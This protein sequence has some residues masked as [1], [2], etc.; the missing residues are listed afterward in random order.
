MTTVARDY[1]NALARFEDK[2]KVRRYSQS[3]CRSYYFMFR[4]FLKAKYP[5][6][7]HHLNKDDIMEYQLQLVSQRNVSR[8]YQNQSI[9]AIKF[10]LEHV[11][12]HDR[13]LFN[14]ERPL[15]EKKL[16]QVL[17]QQEVK[18]ILEQVYN[19][20]H[21]AILTTIYASGLRISELINLEI[22]DIDSA[23]MRI[24][25]WGGKGAKDRF[26]VLSPH[27]LKLLRQYFVKHKP[28]GYLF[29]GANN[30]QPYSTTSIR[31]VLARAVKKAG[32]IKPVTVHTLRHS[33]ATHLLENGTNL[34]YIQ[35]LLGHGSSK[36]TEIYTHVCSTK[37]TDVAS[38]L[39]KLMEKGLI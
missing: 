39:D 10:Y 18:N 22:K 35:E 27:L 5:K 24:W 13:Q 12:G 7:L 1:Q 14:L 37:L 2:L 25:V 32:I 11:L 9:N 6:P 21:K 33:F 28:S 36:T 19:L 30:G 17:N 29:E 26:T 31:K 34:R 8:S 16:P 20:K 38:P 23:N 4:D 15:K 3:T